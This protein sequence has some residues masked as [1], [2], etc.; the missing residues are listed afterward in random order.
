MRTL[1]TPFLI[2]IGLVL[3]Q[4]ALFAGPRVSWLPQ[5][6]DPSKPVR[7]LECVYDAA[8]LVACRE[9]GPDSAWTVTA[10][11]E[12]SM[13][14]YTFTAKRDMKQVGV[15][16]AYDRYDWS[17]NNYVMVPASL[18][19]ANRQRIVHRPYATGLDKSDYYRK[20]LPLSSNPI[21]QFSPDPK[22]TSRFEVLVCNAASP[23][24]G[25]L[26]RARHSATLLLT[27][28][29]IVR[30]DAVRDHGLIGEESADRGLATFVISAPGVRET[31]PQFIGF[32][33]SGDRGIAVKQGET[34]SLRVTEHTFP[35]ADVPAFME[36][37]MR[38]RKRHTATAGVR[39]FLPM[40]EVRRRSHAHIE[41]RFHRGEKGQYYCPENATWMSYGWIGGLMNTY[42]MLALGDEAHLRRVASTFDFALL[43]EGQGKSG[44]FHDTLGADGKPFARGADAHMPGV[45]LVRKNADTL[46][47]MVKQFQ[48]LNAMGHPVKPE[49]EAAV[50]RLADAFVRTWE[51]QGTWGN[52]INVESGDVAL[53]NTTSGAMAPAGLA[54]AAAY[55]KNPAYLATAKAAAK[56]HYDAFVRDGFTS[57]GCG[58]I[59]QNADS[60]TAI[61]LA[62]ALMT[63]HEVTGE[64]VYLTQCAAVANYA[65]S[66]V[67]SFAYRLPTGAPLAKLGANMTGVVW[68]STQ[69]KHSAPGF[70]TQSADVYFKLY[71]LTGNPLYAELLRDVIHG[72]AEGSQ[73][74][75]KITE[76]LGYCDIEF[77]GD[78]ME[79]GWQG[80]GWNETNGAMMALEIPGIY[81]RTDLGTC[82]VFD[83][84]AADIVKREH[85]K[86][87]LRI[88]NPTAFPAT[89]TLFAE[90][91]EAAQRP[92][93]DNAF[94][95]WQNTTVTLEPGA[96]TEVTLP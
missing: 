13:T 28:Q 59:L 46:Y 38:M 51:K 92:L 6:P 37:F 72:H 71:R 52:Y 95:R 22:A 54:L 24:I 44:Y 61:A 86:T 9:V 31:K 73:P 36:A 7:L 42:P 47:W 88:T 2:P 60:E 85:G 45:G 80:T 35:C 91:A 34:L 19:N 3:L 32:S 79:G 87:T 82:Y 64:A 5:T 74:N 12:G 43:S 48:L 55:Y 63:L 26:E 70:C 10:K 17:T 75:G 33:R 40:S 66:W 69:N 81:L 27:D 90:D 4:G 16:V 89:V 25:F 15:A 1:S 14:T 39:D 41:S 58:D 77:R 21:P 65:A 84:V 20:D 57:G 76:R 62:T 68:A 23:I 49:W 53:H 50:K 94:L 78:R 29:G 83:H 30:G 18:Y 11:R 96:T 56:A 8:D 67:C 93:G